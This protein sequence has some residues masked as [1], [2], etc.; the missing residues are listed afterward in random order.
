M[1]LSI[2]IVNY[3]VK[4]FLEHCLH[5]VSRAVNGHRDVEILVVDNASPDD[6]VQM[7]KERFPNVILVENKRNVGF[8]K[9]NNMAIRV[10]RGEYVLLLNPDTV[11][12]QD[13]FA[14]C[15]A[16]MDAHPEAG[17]LGVKMIDGSGNYLPESKRGF[18][19]PWVAFC[20]VF[21]LTA[22]FPK[23]KLLAGYYLGHLSKDSNQEVDVL[24]GAFMM[25]RRSV[26]D[27]IGLLDETFFMY[28]EDIDLSYR[29]VQAGFKN[30]YFSE[31]RI[32][33]YKGESTKKGSLNYVRM[34]Y[35][36][37]II[38]ARKHF[39]GSKAGPFIFIIQT[40]IYVRAFLTLLGNGFKRLG[41]PLIDVILMY[42]GMFLIKVFWEQNV[43]L[44]E[45]VTYPATFTF[46]VVP[47][48]ILI[49]ISGIY[50][51][52]GY[53]K[54]IKLSR[55]LRGLLFG[56][57]F[58]A[59]GYGFLNDSLRFSRAMI[60]LGF[61]YSAVAL[62]SLRLLIHLIKYGNIDIEQL[63]QKRAVVVGSLSEY[64]RVNNLISLSQA[65]VQIE[66]YI[67]VTNCETRYSS[68]GYLGDLPDIK[69]ITTLY[70]IDEIIFCAADVP[71]E[72]IIDLMSS[73]GQGTEYKIVPKESESII[74]SHSKDMQGELYTLEIQLNINTPQQQRNKRMLD[75]IIAIL[76]IPLW[77]LLFRKFRQPLGVWA[78]SILVLTGK[79]SWVGYAGS[80]N[81]NAL[82]A[83]P[84][85]R[86]G[87][88]T[89][90]TPFKKNDWDEG[91]IARLNLLYARDY[92]IY[93]D[94]EI[95]RKSFTQLGGA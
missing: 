79:R 11:V 90:L 92:N 57:I 64:Q 4:Y 19:S 72:K 77:F 51:N 69:D 73:L 49:W 46:I 58:I 94:L 85:I 22:L 3:N 68:S 36:A 26:L 95:I 78:N 28:G 39:G 65:R 41:W 9:A 35:Q 12:Q 2:I 91:T 55:V 93:H 81:G 83:L 59:A 20:K 63:R 42:A 15:I 54:P 74:G 71:A 45:G 87:I 60:L 44:S 56:T 10:S 25:M 84:H 50:F 53:D 13:T 18:P 86:K 88:L 29:I 30:Y 40:A 32:I 80:N 62:I 38:F 14:K 33:H 43:K 34:F 31:T 37:M 66:G 7:L 5:S 89:P 82:T 67:D 17:G 75:I 27:K 47:A 6:S 23:S 1:K 48:Y 76:L 61:A 70:H 21:G 8:A 16:F 24:A 52:G